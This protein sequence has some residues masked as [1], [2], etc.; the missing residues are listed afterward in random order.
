VPTNYWRSVGHSQ[1][2]FFTESYIDELAHRAH[3]D[4][5]AYRRKLLTGEPRLLAVLD[6]A[7]EKADWNTP[8]AAGRF[9]GIA[10]VSCFGSYNA[11]VAE[12]SMEQGRVRVHRVVSAIDCGQA[13]NPPGVV[14]QIQS[15]IVFGLSAAL[16]GEI[17]LDDGRVQQANFHQYEPLR[18]KEM[19][20]VEVHI[21][22]STAAPG[23]IGE[24]GTPAIA[25]AVANAVFSATGKRI[26]R[27]PLS[28]ADL[29]ST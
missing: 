7:A 26:R 18:M 15:A 8:L 29:R 12:I 22:S 4:P 28:L 16:R 19:P 14:Q 3:A 5:V 17:T 9:R 11:Q 1:N 25:P 27:L 23:G 24:T 10:A 20:V 6:M 21:V 13:V 2:T